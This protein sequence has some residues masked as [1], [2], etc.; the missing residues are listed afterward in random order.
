MAAS[1]FL[2][3]CSQCIPVTKRVIFMGLWAN[4]AAFSLFAT[5]A[6]YPAVLCSPRK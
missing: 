3:H 1:M 6:F 4:Q 5:D 2:Q